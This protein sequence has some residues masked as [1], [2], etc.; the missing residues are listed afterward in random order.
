MLEFKRRG[1]SENSAACR[2]TE[3][4]ELDLE[5]GGKEGEVAIGDIPL[6]ELNVVELAE[7][8]RNVR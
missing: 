2:S 7:L 6:S 3:F 8:L 4:K 1:S 5:F